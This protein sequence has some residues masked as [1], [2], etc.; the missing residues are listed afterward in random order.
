M[1]GMTTSGGGSGRFVGRE[2]EVGVIVGALRDAAAGMPGSLFLT[3]PSGAGASRLI[4]EALARL[5]A[6]DDGSP[7]PTILRGDGL[8]AWRGAPYGPVRVALEGLLG[9]RE[10]AEILRLLGPGADLLLPLLPAISAR[11]PDAP[12][13]PASRERLA[14][15]TQEAVRAVLGRLA[16]DGPVVLVLEDLHVLDAASRALLAF[17]ARTLGD[18]PILLLGS[19][20]P[21][22]LGRGHPLRAIFEAVD[23]GPRPARRLEVAP[24]DRSAL[25]ALVEAHEGEPPSAPLLLL[26]AERSAGS[27]LVAEEV[28]AARRELSG[29]SL[30]SPLE[31]LVVARAVRH[32][33]ECRRV[34]RALAV[35]D[36]PVA[37]AELAAIVA[38][39]DE[40]QERPAPRTTR[41]RGRGR[42]GLDADL[43]AGVD[44]AVAAGFAARVGPTGHRPGQ[45]GGD[46]RPVRI[47]HELIAS[48]LAADLLPGPHR[49]MDA[50][51]ARVLSDRPEEAGRHWSLAHETGRELVSEVAAAATAERAGAAVDALGHLER[52]ISLAGSPGA[53]GTLAVS[54][55]LDLLVRAAET[56]VA[57]GDAGRAEAFVQ[58]AIARHPD[59]ADRAASS[60]LTYRLGTYRLAGGDRDGAV[61]AFER[62]LS[63]LPGG[64][65]VERARLLATLAQVRMLD[66]AFSEAT[67]LAEQAM[68]AASGA[69]PEGRAW[70]G[71]SLC[72]QGVVEGWLGRTSGAIRRL[73]EALAIALDEGRFDDAFRARANLA[74]MLDLEGRRDEA[75]EVSRRGIEAA[76]AAGLE[77]V[78]GNLLRGSAVDA[79]VTLGRWREAR[80]MAE[81]ALEWAPSGIPFV[82][83]ALG[84]A[85][86]E[87]ETTAGDAAARLLGRLFLE[88]ETMPDVQF[89][90]PAYQA[91][92][93]LALWRGD[94]ADA[95]RAIGLA[96]SRVRESEDWVLA[97]RAAAAALGVADALADGARDRHDLAAL[98]SA[99]SWA[100]DLLHR[101][102]RIVE[103]SGVPADA[104]VRREAEADLA[105]ARAFAS[106]IHG[107]D[108]P[109]AWAD[110]AGQWRTA[111]HPYETARALH[112]QVEAHLEAGAQSGARREGRDDARAPLL[113]AAAIATDLGAFPLL[114]ELADLAGRARIPLDERS[115]AALAAADSAPLP[116]EV[117]RR[118]AARP[119]SSSRASGVDADRRTAASF[120]LSPREQG[121][122]AEIVAGRTNREIGERLFISE[123]TV[124]VHV[125][126]ILAKLGVGGRVEAATVALRLGLVDDRLE[127]TKKPG[128]GDPGFRG[129]RRGG[130][131]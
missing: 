81:R 80:E 46:N 21:D 106:R 97:A 122:L 85:I 40:G 62:A 7:A 103:S 98:A 65:G 107:H 124:G 90:V 92:A 31:Q 96:W 128:P 2:R 104:R 13:G 39:F 56:S 123:K 70:Y 11:L 93:S 88:L 8:P 105:T 95:Q 33:R 117:D 76:E 1:P 75:V 102:T 50:A 12:A 57:A 19:Y 114:R 4:D 20:Q 58:S 78:H 79:L 73:E 121:V 34:L 113:E 127:R 69:G 52:A 64:P 48:A 37:P 126:N 17:L 118:A 47:R 119:G 51:L 108:D 49:R 100:D 125:G 18:R 15:R 110:V 66:G 44:E 115:L 16:A 3:G 59:P 131:A 54:D 87:V 30:S 91:A 61:A 22:A 5:A 32:S 38:A 120:G 109:G 63:L 24:L 6:G 130:A 23:G 27:P 68:A 60:E 101:A 41:A 42:D 89:A 111:R 67:V 99:R 36:G 116:P 43:A 28:L 74:T 14:E 112:H 129:R 45:R 82:N 10:P 77:V 26:V 9:S 84:L 55:E 35:A 83:A 86:I 53:I 25:R 94:P 72:T 29:A 71:H